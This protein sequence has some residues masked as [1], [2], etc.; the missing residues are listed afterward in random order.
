MKFSDAMEQLKL[1]YKVT[2]ESWKDGIYFLMQDNDVKSF[3]PIL[4]PYIYNEDIMVS[5]GWR[6]DNSEQ[7]MKFVDIIPLLQAGGCAKMREWKD[8]YIYFDRQEGRLILRAMEQFQFM[9]EFE[10]FVAEDWV[11][12]E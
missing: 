5:Y 1:G 3:H 8:S 11:V 2:R 9:P 10:A 4:K 12:I 6:V 7:E